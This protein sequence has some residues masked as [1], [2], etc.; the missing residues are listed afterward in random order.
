MPEI[1]F[2]LSSKSNFGKKA[3][4]EL[5]TISEKQFKMPI[6]KIIQETPRS[7]LII[8]P[9]SQEK[10]QGMRHT[11]RT[12]KKKIQESMDSVATSTVMNGRLS[13]RKFD[14]MRKAE[15]LVETPTRKR[16]CP[17]DENTPTPK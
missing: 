5:N 3:L 12:T 11:V 15:G 2:D 13:W 4:K 7:R 1:K 16:S 8:K 6:Q 10:Q 9:T 14:Q 17:T